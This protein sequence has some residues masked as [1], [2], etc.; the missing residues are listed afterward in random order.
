[1]W[2]GIMVLEAEMEVKPEYQRLV[3]EFLKAMDLVPA[4]MED[5]KVAME[6]VYD[7]VGLRIDLVNADLVRK[8]KGK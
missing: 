5:F 7:E 1:M 6:H 2:K 3:D 8:N 4:D